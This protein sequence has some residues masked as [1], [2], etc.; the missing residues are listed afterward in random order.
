MKRLV[1]ALSAVVV[2]IFSI[3]VATE[4]DYHSEVSQA[5]IDPMIMTPQQA[6]EALMSIV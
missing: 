6:Y 2:V 3:G 4:I 5:T 1:I